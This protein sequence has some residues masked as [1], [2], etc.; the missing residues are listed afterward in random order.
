MNRLVFEVNP[1]T[2][3]L[4]MTRFVKQPVAL[5]RIYLQGMKH[6]A[7]SFVRYDLDRGVVE[8]KN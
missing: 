6:H 2:C 4:M 5:A 8:I 1:S 3:Y 7:R